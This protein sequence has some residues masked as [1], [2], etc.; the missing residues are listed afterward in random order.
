MKVVLSSKA[1]RERI[2]FERERETHIVG[3]KTTHFILS[4][5]QHIL[6]LD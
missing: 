6:P 1:K 4:S 5:P 3:A 2:R